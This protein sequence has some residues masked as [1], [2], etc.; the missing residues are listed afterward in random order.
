MYSLLLIIIYLAFISLGLPDSLLGSAWPVMHRALDVP[1]AF[2]GII[3][4]VI[5][6]GT[7]VS[8]LLSDRLTK[9]F[10][11]GRVTAVSVLFTAI[12]LLGFAYAQS[13]TLLLFFSIPYG[14]G[15]GAVD[16]ALNNYVA[17]HYASRHMN[18][19]HS[20]WGL[21]A[22]IS[23]YI[24]GYFLT[25]G[26]AYTDGYFFIA[27][28]Q[29]GLS[30]VLFMSLPLWKK[31]TDSKAS[32]ESND[33][34]ISMRQTVKIKGVKLVLIT[35]FGYCAIESTT[36][37]WASSFLVE[38]R[39]LGA[40]VAAR[41]TS[42]FFIGI[43]TGRF[44]AGFFSER[45]GDKF[46]IRYG[47]FT[48]MAGVSLLMLNHTSNNMYMVSLIIIGL[49]CAPIYPA[50]IHSTPVNFPKEY[51]QSIIG[52]QMASAYLGTT[53]MPP[54]FGFIASITSIGYFPFYLLLISL[55]ML[56][57]SERLNTVL[58]SKDVMT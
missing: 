11:T 15:A 31:P 58:L 35:F 43:T 12:A 4:I 14:I 45:I 18:W 36:G 2:A 57:F 26:R 3:T 16:A 5:S 53:I 23:P 20:F 54:L 29:M 28:L 27:V 42:Y 40:E 19:L 8:S 50:I 30:F 34:A 49:G 47:T 25:G 52:I 56:L 7:I 13:F 38:Y 1:I 48:I 55:C 33:Q 44:L 32:K 37:L 6:V 22:S 21:G 46:L 17:V 10:G 24:M 39:G 9:K 51:S 41:F